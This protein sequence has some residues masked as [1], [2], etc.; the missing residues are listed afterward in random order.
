MA[1]D[2]FA[3]VA[4]QYAKSRPSYPPEL[5]AFLASVAPRRRL[6]WDCGT[7]S[8]Q[9]AVLLAAEF[10]KV[11]ATDESRAQLSHATP[12]PNVDFRGALE[13]DSGL[14]DASCDLVTA[15]QAA[16]WFDL[17]AFSPR[18]GACWCLVA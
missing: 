13:R 5:A 8:G 7:G 11:V 2:H 12:H 4:A 3:S 14:S 17:P 15:A 1:A 6:A 18:R 16:H 10:E 9:A